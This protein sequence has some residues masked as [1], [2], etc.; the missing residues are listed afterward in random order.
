MDQ[1]L[2]PAYVGIDVSKDRLDVHLLPE[3]KS[4]AVTRD[5]AGL[6]SLTTLLLER[7]VA[8]VVLEATGGFEITVAAA[9]AGA[10]LPTAV[11]NPRQIRSFARAAGRLAKTDA[12]D[13][14]I[15]ARFGEQMRPEPRAVPDEQALLLAE[16]VTRR[17]QLIEMIKAEGNRERQ[18]RGARVARRL[19]AHGEWLRKEL[20]ELE[21]DIG[22]TVRG[23][24]I[25]RE[26]EDL[27][28]SVPGIGPTT[29]RALI[30]EMPELGKLD[31]RSSAALAGL[32]PI[33]RDSGKFRG[34]RFIGGGRKSV[35][36][37]LYMAT[38]VA[39]RYNPAIRAFFK[40]LRARGKPFKVA[41]TAA[42]R[43]L[44][45]ILN[46]VLREKKPW[47]NA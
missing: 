16:L 27:L 2:Q 10:R 35:R 24:P 21:T 4:F 19:K 7:G 8:L 45:T 47:Q 15:I 26:T 42:M 25:W 20:Q 44:L 28:V 13:A 3:G 9:L 22:D 33:A 11:T 5:G 32:A 36:T 12:L 31:R 30:A 43:K 14:E 29:A 38:V 39:A 17:T 46:A 23:S 41:L 34:R 37:A 6:S 18:A 1:P 40:T